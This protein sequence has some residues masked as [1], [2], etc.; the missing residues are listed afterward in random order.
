MLILEE[1]RIISIS[2]SSAFL[3]FSRPSVSVYDSL[4]SVS[5]ACLL[6]LCLVLPRI[7]NTSSDSRHPCPVPLWV[8]LLLIIIILPKWKS[9]SSTLDGCHP[10]S[11]EVLTQGKRL[12][13]LMNL[14]ASFLPS[15]VWEFPP[16]LVSIPFYFTL[17]LCF[18]AVSPS[19]DAP[20]LAEAQLWEKAPHPPYPPPTQFWE[21]MVFLEKSREAARMGWRNSVT[22]HVTEKAPTQ[23]WALGIERE[24]RHSHCP[25]G[26]W[27]SWGCTE[28]TTL[29]SR[30]TREGET[31]CTMGG[32]EHLSWSWRASSYWRKS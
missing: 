15:S 9:L 28:S 32:W 1:L 20:L 3:R 18:P 8:S 31:D 22:Q 10:A 13:Y 14:L 11:L 23:C 27:S 29:W 24:R 25:Q 19:R 6:I 4:L 26:A 16:S 7:T 5:R 21:R 30:N 2:F 17:E 12:L